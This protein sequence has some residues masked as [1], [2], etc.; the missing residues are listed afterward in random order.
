VFATCQRS[1]AVLTPTALQSGGRNATDGA[2]SSG[3]PEETAAG[4]DDGVW[5]AV[6]LAEPPPPPQ[7]GGGRGGE[8][9]V[10]RNGQRRRL[11]FD[12]HE[13]LLMLAVFR[14]EGLCLHATKFRLARR[15]TAPNNIRAAVPCAVRAGR[16]HQ[17]SY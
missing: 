2:P 12:R 11:G 6:L 9:D 15:T 10:F 8:R 1:V 13:P 14:Y 16:P 7:G 4:H 5:S 17:P 3:A